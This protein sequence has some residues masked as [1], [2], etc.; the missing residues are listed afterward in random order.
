MRPASCARAAVHLNGTLQ[1]T[2]APLGPSVPMFPCYTQ[3]EK[4]ALFG[5]DGISTTFSRQPIMTLVVCL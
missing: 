5:L 1:T 2:A 4:L 3:E